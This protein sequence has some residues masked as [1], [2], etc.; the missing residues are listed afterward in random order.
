MQNF[1][2]SNFGKSKYVVHSYAAMLPG[3]LVPFHSAAGSVTL[4]VNRSSLLS[5]AIYI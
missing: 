1:H 4:A 3:M 5:L 2:L